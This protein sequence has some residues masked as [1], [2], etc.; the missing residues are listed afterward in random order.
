MAADLQ[1][2]SDAEMDVDE[3]NVQ[4]E[5]EG[6]GDNEGDDEEAEIEV[7]GEDSQS[8]NEDDGP[9]T[10][11]TT[12]QPTLKITLKLPPSNAF[13][14]NNSPRTATPEELDHISFKRTPRQRAKTKVIQDIDIESEDPTSPSVASDDAAQSPRE[15]GSWSTGTPSASVKL[16]TTR[17]A[18]L[19]SVVDSSHVSLN[20][21]SKSKKQPLNETELALRKEETARKRKNLSEKKLEDEKAETINRLLKKQSRPKNKRTTALDDRSPLPS[22]NVQEGEEADGDEEEDEAMDIVEEPPKEVRPVMYRWVSSL[23]VA[24]SIENADRQVEM[25][26]TFSVPEAFIPPQVNKDEYQAARGPGLCAVEGCGK[27]RKYRVLRDWTTGACDSTH[28]R[29]VA[30]QV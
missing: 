3:V 20:K 8:V 9:P 13:G 29:I 26:I 2:P 7:S 19:A 14:S 12:T 28:L 1:S 11:P 21:G 22:S 17:Q 27:P 23:R 24:P 25:G 18:V 5:D 15:S 4:T 16:M 10:K 30:N 6:W